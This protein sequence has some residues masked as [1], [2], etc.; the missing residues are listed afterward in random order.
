MIN[1]SF[2]YGG[3]EKI[4]QTLYNALNE[5]PGF[6]AYFAYGRRSTERDEKTFKFSLKSEIYFHALLTRLTGLQGYGSWFS[7]RRLERFVLEEKFDLIHLHNLHG[8]YLNLDFIKFL[9]KLN[10][11]IVWTLHDAWPITGR[12]CY[13][14]GCERWKKGCGNCPHLSWPPKTYF[15]SSAL[16]WKKKKEYFTQDWNPVIVCPSRWMAD[17]VRES[18]LNKYRIEVIPN[19]VDA[20]IFK[21]RDKS[22][23]R[24]KIGI[25]SSKKIILS[26][27]VK[28]NE[29]RKGAKYCFEAL[30]YIRN[31]NWMIVTLGKKLDLGAKVA[32]NINIKQLGYISDPNL[33]SEIYN[34]ADIFCTTSLD[35]T[36][37]TTVLEAMAC[38]IPIAGFKAGGIPEQ[39]SPDC[40]ILVEAKN[41]KTLAEAID[42]LLDNDEQRKI[43]SLNCRKRTLEN[44][45][46]EKFKERYINLYRTVFQK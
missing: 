15:D 30:K 17:R 35:D 6:S 44:Y 32:K 21:P 5:T 16:M 26:I 40:G 23:I 39:V 42:T 7:T 8:Y 3:A 14:L 20:S 9:G 46:I 24:K 11:P 27:A 18:Y 2:S 36:F 1:N 13:F 37:P 28:L 41:V 38:G 25:P 19:G 12:C 4:A 45:S 31:R 10:I 43:F 33:I 22:A 34:A 29:E